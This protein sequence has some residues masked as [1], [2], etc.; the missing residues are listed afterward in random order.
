MHTMGQ[1]RSAGAGSPSWPMQSIRHIRFARDNS[2]KAGLKNRGAP[3]YNEVAVVREVLA[4]PVFDDCEQGRC[5]GSPYFG[6]ALNLVLAILESD[7]DF[8]EFR[9]DGRR[10]EPAES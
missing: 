4:T 1:P 3:A 8:F 10:F 9:Y 7:G 5:A 2:W 6:E